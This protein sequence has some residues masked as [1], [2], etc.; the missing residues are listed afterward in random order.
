[1]KSLLRNLSRWKRRLM[2]SPLALFLDYDGTLAPIALTPARARL[3][4]ETRQI[5]L[6]LSR[7]KDV[8]IAIVSGRGLKDLRR[9]VSVRGLSYVGSHGLELETDGRVASAPSAMYLRVLGELRE[10]VKCGLKSVRGILLEEKPF[11][12]A[13]HY[14]LAAASR[15]DSI[16]RLVRDVCRKPLRDGAISVLPGKKVIEILPAQADHKGKSV[17]RLLRLWKG[18]FTSVFIGDDRTDETA[19]AFLKRRGLTIRVGAG[20]ERSQAQYYVDSVEEAR[21]FLRLILQLRSSR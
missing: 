11:S 12:L 2:D 18:D 13:I 3:P 9:M 15:E 20:R 10:H 16:L 8:R 19:F 4:R 7:L 21:F 14:R 17:Q 5:L 6:G 1:M